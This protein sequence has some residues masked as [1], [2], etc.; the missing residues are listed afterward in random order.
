MRLD[1]FLSQA[2]LGS[3]RQTWKLVRKGKVKVNSRIIKDPAFKIDPE[4]D[5]IEI[6]NQILYLTSQFYYYKFYKPKGY[7]TST[8]DLQP[9]VM[10]L[11]PKELPGFSKI[12]PV[13]RLDKDAEGLLIL[14][15]DG[16]LAHR[17]LHPKWKLSKIYELK[18]TPR[19]KE[20]DKEFLEKGIELSEGKTKPCQ[21]EF[22]N[23]DK[24]FLKITVFEGRYHLLKRMFGKLGY[25]VLH[26]RRIAIG[27]VK[28]ENLKPG[29]IR[30]LSHSEIEAIKSLLKC[31]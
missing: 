21:I 20:E 15:N 7:I 26:I 30:K 1:K 27:P 24:D 13:G 18:I 10:D 11:I 6:N 25:K 23:K 4:K 22:L 3:R 16:S 28:L 8:K 31:L 2:G 5:L 9:T 14:T 17:L 12:F 19:L 29:E